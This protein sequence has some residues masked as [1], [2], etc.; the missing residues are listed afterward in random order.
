[1][2]LGPQVG[3][4][5][6]HTV[7]WEPSSPP[8]QGKRGQSPQ[9]AAHICSGQMAGWITMLLGREVGLSP[10]DIVLD[11]DP[12]PPPQKGSTAPIFGP[13]LLSPDGCMDQ[14]ATWHGARSRPG[15]SV[16]WGPSSPLP[17]G[18]RSPQIFGCGQM[19]GWIKMPLCREV[20]LS[21]SDIVLGEDLAPLPQKGADPN[22]RPMS[23]VAKR[24]AG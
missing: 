15:H 6:G 13:C 16:R 8:L 14:D 19:A 5:P 21:R 17:K 4:G 18:G 24:L 2:K 23:I 1:M 7:K 9:F 22:F 12:A 20:G 11:G 3:L 10:S